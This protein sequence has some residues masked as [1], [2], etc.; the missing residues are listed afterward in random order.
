MSDTAPVPR[1][2]Y[3]VTALTGQPP[4][5]SGAV[6]RLAES[7]RQLDA[8]VV[9]LPPLQRVDT[10]TE[11][12]LDVLLLVVAGRGTLGTTKGSEPLGEGRLIW[13][14]HGSTRSV[15]AGAEGLSYLTVHRRRP[16]MRIGHHPPGEQPTAARD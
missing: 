4:E 7:G 11:P 6:W 10:H 8:N 5:T 16:G 2:L 9:H 15:T 1:A 3:D 12:E 14:P 13:L